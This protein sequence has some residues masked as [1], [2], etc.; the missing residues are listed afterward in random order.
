MKF[1]ES[2]MQSIKLSKI[3][4]IIIISVLASMPLALI[5]H[6]GVHWF[7][8][9]FLNE[10]NEPKYL[11]YNPQA[12]SNNVDDVGLLFVLS[13]V[14]NYRHNPA[15]PNAY[16]D[17]WVTRRSLMIEEISAM[18]VTIFIMILFNIIFLYKLLR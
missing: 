3:I 16:A 7:S 14:N 5:A 13:D 4:W 15:V 10:F 6:E 17:D 9:T 8:G 1:Q 18:I 12:Y 11:C 2:K